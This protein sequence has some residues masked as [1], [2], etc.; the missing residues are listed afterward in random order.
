MLRMRYR[1]CSIPTAHICFQ[2]ILPGDG[3]DSRLSMHL[4]VV[5]AAP[6]EA[7]KTTA[8]VKGMW[9]AFL[10]ADPKPRYLFNA[11]WA[12]TRI[13]GPA[14]ARVL[15]YACKKESGMKLITNHGSTSLYGTAIL[16]LATKD[17]LSR[18]TAEATREPASVISSGA[19]KLWTRPTRTPRLRA[20]CL[21]ETHV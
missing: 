14:P 7:T 15:V 20:S 13:L 17:G 8:N 5:L 11:S 4:A 19:R 16:Q 9:P 1:A 21:N 6:R 18:S 10:N 3:C 2:A 12:F